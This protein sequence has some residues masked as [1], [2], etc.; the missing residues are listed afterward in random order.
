MLLISVGIATMGLFNIQSSGAVST[1]G[2]LTFPIVQSTW[3][4]PWVFLAGAQFNT[5]NAGFTTL[6]ERPLF[7]WAAG[8]Q[9]SF[10]PA[11]SEANPSNISWNGNTATITMYGNKWSNGETVN[12]QSAAFWI[13]LEKWAAYASATKTAYGNEWAFN[14]GAYAPGVGIPDQVSNVSASGN[15]LKIT[16]S[17]TVNRD[18]ALNNAFQTITPIPLSWDV[19]GASKAPGSAGCAKANTYASTAPYQLTG[20]GAT[21]CADVFKYLSSIAGAGGANATYKGISNNIWKVSDGPYILQSVTQLPAA[22]NGGG[23]LPVFTANTSYMGADKAQAKTLNWK[24][25]TSTTAEVNALATGTYNLA[26]GGVPST[27]LTNGS[28][29]AGASD[30][31][32]C[33]KAYAS[34]NEAAAKAAGCNGAY[35]GTIK[36]AS[37]AK[38]YNLQSTSNWGVSYAY[39]N[40]NPSAAHSAELSQAYVRRVLNLTV[41]QSGLISTV[42]RGYAAPNCNLIPQ[43]DDPY[44]NDTSCFGASKYAA[45]LTKAASLLTSN[46]W[47]KQSGTYVCTSPGTA[48]GDCGAGIA[49]N[50]PLAINFE[51]LYSAGSDSATEVADLKSTWDAFGIQTTL[52]PIS[53]SQTILNDVYGAK[54]TYDIALYGG[55]VF[56][57]GV[58]VSG[59]Q[60]ALTGSSGMV[61][62]FS[63]PTF[64]CSIL[65]TIDVTKPAS[66]SSYANWVQ[67]SS[68]NDS[69]SLT[70]AVHNYADLSGFT[71]SNSLAPFLYLPNTFWGSTLV[72]K[73]VTWT[74]PKPDN[75]FGTWNTFSNPVVNFM[76]QWIKPKA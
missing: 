24:Y 26:T 20:A 2:T 46:G 75:A 35:P 21:A 76:P 59:E 69:A 28:I 72:S 42:F 22:D 48:A 74:G 38:R 57:P 29:V 53:Q 1:S 12:A 17:T 71:A 67:L 50:T 51:Y 39:F 23:A 68:G 60:F 8:N 66:C 34:A 49:A 61:E 19:T 4:D 16:F 37:V 52:N 47:T 73:N 41:D 56:N 30:S 27:D 43:I 36:V 13:N 33:D 55:W 9:T 6:S 45:N 15:T 65:N 18:W 3:T 31:A 44:Q 5:V 70:T 10:D 63:N 62:G 40:Q 64:D 7:Y 54:P 14:Y 32:A 11:V 25:F 58:F